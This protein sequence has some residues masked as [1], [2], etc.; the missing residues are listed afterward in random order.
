MSFQ[1]VLPTICN[2]A[3]GAKLLQTILKSKNGVHVFCDTVVVSDSFLSSCKKP[4]EKLLQTKAEKV[5]SCMAK[6]R[7]PCTC[8]E[9][10]P[11][12][13]DCLHL[14][15]WC[16]LLLQVQVYSSRHQLIKKDQAPQWRKD[17]RKTGRNSEGRKLW[18]G[19]ES[20][21]PLSEV[22]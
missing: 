12:S 6:G 18:V 22:F 15:S 20:A 21:S 2:E 13:F 16:R 5:G 8:I 7:V 19:L 9:Q 1:P 11:H 14:H 17:Q 3:D 10:K 4:F